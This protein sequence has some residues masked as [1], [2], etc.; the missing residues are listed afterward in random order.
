MTD[1]QTDRQTDGQTEIETKAE[2]GGGREKR[3]ACGTREAASL[4]FIYS[5]PGRRG[6]ACV[7]AAKAFGQEQEA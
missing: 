3:L 5:P 2:T 7:D 4:A 6:L 1:R